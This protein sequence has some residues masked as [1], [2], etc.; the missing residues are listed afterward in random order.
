MSLGGN[1]LAKKGRDSEM[2]WF[3]KYL[4]KYA[5]FKGRAC[6]TEFAMFFFFCLVIQF[7]SLWLLKMCGASDALVRIISGVLVLALG[8]PY[9]A[10][11]VRR[12]HDIGKSGERLFLIPI[13]GFV[14][15][16]L[17]VETSKDLLHADAVI[18]TILTALS[19]VGSAWLFFLT[20]A[21][22]V[23]KGGQGENEYGSDP[24]APSEVV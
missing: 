13:L 1:K 6:R 16:L 21:M 15:L 24:K 12:L 14:G 9:L 7:S 22:F 23:R 8:I 3:L 17:H 11:L 5:D 19:L 18:L 2:E 4:R 20:L 10:V